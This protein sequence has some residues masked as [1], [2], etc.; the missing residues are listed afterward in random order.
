MEVSQVNQPSV[1]FNTETIYK[2]NQR[3]GF[4]IKPF[5]ETI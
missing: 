4:Y 5:A 1:A 3:T 2:A